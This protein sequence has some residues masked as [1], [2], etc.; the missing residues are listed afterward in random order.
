LASFLI[1][2]AMADSFHF[3]VACWEFQLGCLLK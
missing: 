3:T 1:S 2:L